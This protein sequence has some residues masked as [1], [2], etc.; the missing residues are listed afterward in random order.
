MAAASGRR[1][2]GAAGPLAVPRRGG[3]KRAGGGAIQPEYNAGFCTKRAGAMQI[4]HQVHKPTTG[5]PE[6]DRT[7]EI[8]A[9][10]PKKN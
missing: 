7:Q 5:T 3:A 9:R 10:W 8:S 1:G 4:H 2:T 6:A